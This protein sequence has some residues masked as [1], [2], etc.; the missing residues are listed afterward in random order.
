MSDAVIS[1]AQP[2]RRSHARGALIAKV[3]E[4]LCFAAATALLATLGGLLVSLFIGGWPV[5][6]RFGLSFFTSSTWNPVTD[7]YGAAGP[8][9]GTLGT[10]VIALALSLPIA[11]GVAF[12]LTELCPAKLRRPIGTAVELLAG[13]PS[14][15]YGMWGLFVFAPLFSKYVQMPLMMAAKPGFE[16]WKIPASI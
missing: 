6:R 9:V 7:V 4:G 15:V 2:L 16:P 3:F 1:S 5:F 13:I 14:I 8:I 12:F 10:A 11:G